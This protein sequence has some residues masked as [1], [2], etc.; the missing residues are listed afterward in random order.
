V[1]WRHHFVLF[2]LVPVDFIPLSQLSVWEA[3]QD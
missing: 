1:G 2:T 3:W